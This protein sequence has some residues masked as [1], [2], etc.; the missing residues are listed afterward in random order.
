MKIEIHWCVSGDC[1]SRDAGRDQAEGPEWVLPLPV[2]RDHWQGVTRGTGQGR[3]WERSKVRNSFC[4]TV[5]WIIIII[6]VT[7][8]CCWQQFVCV[9]VCVCV[10]A[11][12]CVQVCVCVCVCVCAMSVCCCTLAMHL[13]AGCVWAMDYTSL[14]SY[15][16]QSKIQSCL[17]FQQMKKYC[18]Q[19]ALSVSCCLNPAYCYMV[20]FVVMQN[21]SEEG[22]HIRC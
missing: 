12:M 18:N 10:C 1:L 17:F 20:A 15:C 11:C 13:T 21:G 7:F 9:C 2:Q 8:C 14:N 22:T 5:M 6:C 3:D 16:I 19:I 4:F